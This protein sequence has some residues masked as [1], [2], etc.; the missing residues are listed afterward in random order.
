MQVSQGFDIGF[1][2]DVLRLLTVLHFK[3]NKAVE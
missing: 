2:G 3:I 1:L